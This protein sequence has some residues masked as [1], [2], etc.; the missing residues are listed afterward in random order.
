MMATFL[1]LD[2][3]SC[4][5]LTARTADDVLAAMSQR[6]F[7][8]YIFDLWMPVV[9]GLE[10]CGRGRPRDSD[11]PI[12]IYSALAQSADRVSAKLAGADMF[13]VKPNDIESESML[14]LELTIRLINALYKFP[15]PGGALYRSDPSRNQP[16][17]EDS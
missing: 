7:D 6:P 10:L 8:L 16:M 17:R 11:V 9:N 2:C 5:V 12:V 3:E 1:L 13:L 4:D 15:A 14:C